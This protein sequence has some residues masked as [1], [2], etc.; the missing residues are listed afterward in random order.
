MSMRIEIGEGY[1]EPIEDNTRWTRMCMNCNAAATLIH[2]EPN[3][4]SAKN[5]PELNEGSEWEAWKWRILTQY[6]LMKVVERCD[7][8]EPELDTNIWKQL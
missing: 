8:D 4:G 1:M 3:L 5:I 2:E 6:L 7:C